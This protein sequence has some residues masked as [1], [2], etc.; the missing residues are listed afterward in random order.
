[1]SYRVIS[2]TEAA[3]MIQHGDNIGLSGFTPAGTAKAVTYALAEKAE[4]EHKAGRPFQVGVFTGASTGDSCDGI[5]SRAKAITI[6][7]TKLGP[8]GSFFLCQNFVINCPMT[9]AQ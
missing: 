4:T 7:L 3:D 5:L 6:C 8:Y 2:A 1:M 9:E